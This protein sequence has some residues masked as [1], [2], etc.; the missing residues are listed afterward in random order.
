MNTK[1]RKI[2]AERHRIELHDN[3]W[4]FV[5]PVF[6]LYSQP[7]KMNFTE[8]VPFPFIWRNSSSF[9]NKSTYIIGKLLPV[10]WPKIKLKLFL[11]GCSEVG[12][13]NTHKHLIVWGSYRQ[14]NCISSQLFKLRVRFIASLF[15]FEMWYKRTML[16]AI[17]ISLQSHIKESKKDLRLLKGNGSSK[18]H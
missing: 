4:F 15:L 17:M 16:S 2:R 12:P 1:V 7:Y 11:L 14:C 13:Q 5:L 9:N 8:T 18:S 3:T 6:L 10:F